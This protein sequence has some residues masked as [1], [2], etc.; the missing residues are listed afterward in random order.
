MVARKD[1]AQRRR[2]ARD[3]KI[4]VKACAAATVQEHA[5]VDVSHVHGQEAVADDDLAALWSLLPPQVDGGDGGDSDI[6][7]PE[8]CPLAVDADS[9]VEQLLPGGGAEHL[10]D[11][12]GELESC[13]LEGDEPEE[14]ED[15]PGLMAILAD[16]SP[17]GMRRKIHDGLEALLEGDGLDWCFQRN[18]LRNRDFRRISLLPGAQIRGV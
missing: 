16:D 5:D 1:L 9:D 18:D 15:A 8:L 3:A 10:L 17:H 11:Q 12:L 2:D 14:P 4:G 13:Q 7:M 6:D